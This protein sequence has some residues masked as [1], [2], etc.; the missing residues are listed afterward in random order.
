MK[1]VELQESEQSTSDP[2]PSCRSSLHTEAWVGEV[3]INM[4]RLVSLAVFYG[5]HVVN[6][7]VFSNDAALQ[8]HF[9]TTVSLTVFM[10]AAGAVL[11]HLI[12][13][14]R[15]MFPALS[16]TVIAW[17][18]TLATVL[19]CVCQNPLSTLVCVYFLIVASAALRFSLPPVYLA[20]LGSLLGYLVFLGYLRFVLQ[21]PDE[22]RV[23]RPNQV[24][25]AIE[26]VV[27]GLFAGQS[28]R[29]ARRVAAG[30]YVRSPLDAEEPQ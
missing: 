7:F 2:P 27:A 17:D 11:L 20:T 6:T 13:L 23:S 30:S 28:V 10:W 9:H 29:Q 4:I 1:G 3:R 14:R 15:V 21:L 8:A 5:Y 19:L 22:L 24:I 16:L 12:L 18:L 26:L 25:T